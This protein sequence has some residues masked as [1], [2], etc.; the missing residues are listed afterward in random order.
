MTE[1]L[2]SPNEREISSLLRT[3][4]QR[5][6]LRAI[7]QLAWGIIISLFAALFISHLNN[8][9]SSSPER[10]RERVQQDLISIQQPWAEEFALQ[11]ESYRQWLGRHAI[12]QEAE[13]FDS[14]STIVIHSAISS[15]AASIPADELGFLGKAYLAFHTGAVRVLFFVFASAR[16]CL[17]AALVAFFFGITGVNAYTKADAL[18]QMGNGRVFYSGAR[19]GLEKLASNGAPDVQIRGF[20]CPQFSTTAEAQASSIWRV[21]KQHGAT[22]ATNEFL[23]RILVKNGSTAS[24]VAFPEEEELLKRSF[25]GEAVASNVAYL[26]DATLQLHALYRAGEVPEGTTPPT[27]QTEGGKALS[28]KE[29]AQRVRD[30][31]HQVLSPTMRAEIAT[32]SSHEI[33]TALLALESGKILAH[34]FEGG[35]WVRRSNFPH[36]SARAVLHSVVEYPKDYS[37]EQRTR[38]RRALIYAARK[39]AF[40]P[41]RM[42]IDMTDDCWVLRQWMEVFLACPHE[43]TAVTDEVELVGIVRESHQSWCQEFFE[44]GTVLTPEISAHS[45]ST[46]TELLFLPVVRVVTLLRKVVPSARISRMHYLLER[47]RTKQQLQRLHTPDSDTGPIEQLSFD[48]VDTPPSEEELLTIAQLHGMRRDD[49]SD[50]L[51]LKVVLSSYGW[52][53]SR[54]GDYS[55]PETSTIFAVFKPENQLEGTNSLGLLGKSGMVPVRGSK[56]APRWGRQWANRFVYVRKVTMAETVEDY[57]K[58]L[59][60]IEDI[61]DPIDDAAAKQSTVVS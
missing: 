11:W 41:V 55:V 36:L 31:L 10:D 22:N 3:S 33:A 60:G 6:I 37:F 15:N 45:Y 54:V 43:L 9:G 1:G 30:S 50:W 28:S 29:F 56:L 5:R 16:L 18:G 13:L 20:A 53:A 49:L 44:S 46:S 21:I 59:Q 2:T 24:Y 51:A 17:V 61:D 58:L 19:A 7:I 34:S 4:K 52:L 25:S 27:S 48:R 14:L 42:P 39:S 8:S 23:T 32:I 35:R 38:I 40:A 47:V 57:E 26:L 12:R